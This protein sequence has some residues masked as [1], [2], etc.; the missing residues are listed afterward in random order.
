MFDLFIQHLETIF[1]EGA[2]EQMA[3]E[4]PEQ[5]NFLF[6]QFIDSYGN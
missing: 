5:Y 6:N 1:W 2:A 3:A 4:Q